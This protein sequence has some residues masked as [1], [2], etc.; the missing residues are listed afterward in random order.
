MKDNL[1]LKKYKNENVNGTFNLL[2]ENT[3]FGSKVIEIEDDII[4]DDKSI[5]YFQ[6]YYNVTDFNDQI[7]VSL[8]KNNGYQYYE[9]DSY[10]ENF[11][12]LDSVDL[13]YN[14]HS[15][16]MAQQSDNDEFKLN[17]MYQLVSVIPPQSANLIHKKYRHLIVEDGN[18]SYMCP[19]DFNLD[20]AGKKN[21][22]EAIAILPYL[23]LQKIKQEVDN[24]STKHE[25]GKNEGGE[26]FKYYIYTL[27]AGFT[28]NTIHF[29][30]RNFKHKI[31][32][33]PKQ[34]EMTEDTEPIDDENSLYSIL[35]QKK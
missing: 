12:I 1:I 8:S 31:K 28:F 5:Q 16:I 30:K 4:I 27:P 23:N 3:F 19:L 24:V 11:F 20:F 2:E 14:N 13:K 22:F 15:I 35:K 29:V 7:Q 17:F 32:P 18:L 26:Y 9:L 6:Y 21:D 10:S 34:Q 25:R 33:K